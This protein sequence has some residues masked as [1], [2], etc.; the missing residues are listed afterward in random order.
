MVHRFRR[1]LAIA[2]ALA[3]SF[4]LTGLRLGG[5]QPPLAPSGAIAS[6]TNP[7]EGLTVKRFESAGQRVRFASADRG[8]R[9][10]RLSMPAG[11]AADAR[12]LAFVDQYGARFGL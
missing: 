4:A 6:A 7:D 5:Q 8:R 11:A 9:G 3:V 1:R 10:I 12:A 2:F